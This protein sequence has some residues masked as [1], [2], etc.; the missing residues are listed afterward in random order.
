M[1]V[2]LPFTPTDRTKPLV[3][4]RIAC[5]RA[6]ETGLP[7]ASRTVPL[8]VRGALGAVK[9]GIAKLA[10]DVS[11]SCTGTGTAELKLRAPG[12]G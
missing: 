6:N 7:A 4:G 2:P 12:P 9:P 8:I 5:T 1:Y 3:S 10:F 11:P